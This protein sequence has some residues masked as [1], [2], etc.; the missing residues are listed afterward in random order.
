MSIVL[1][2]GGNTGLGYESAKKLKTLGHKVYIGCRNEE[3]GKKAANELGV[4][5]IQMDIIDDESVK[6]GIETLQQKEDHLDV[7]INNAGIP[8][9]RIPAQE[10]TADMM[11]KIYDVNVFGAVRVIH[12]CLAML[13]KSDN[14]VIV[15]VSS[16]MG[17]FG[18]VLNPDKIESKVT[19]PIYCSSKAALSM[20][21]VQ[22]SKALPQIKINVVDPGPT[23]TGDNF[24]HGIQTVEEGI[25]AI[26]RMAII[27]KNGPSGTFSN[28]DGILPW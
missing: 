2:T 20:L 24:S 14:P 16:G 27:D 11:K 8:G 13:E 12:E 23:K 25:E 9:S 17:S 7:L 1:I 22:Y 6:N 15:N 19:S 26:I 18:Q 3:K 21:S 10:I 28:K 4:N 5:Y